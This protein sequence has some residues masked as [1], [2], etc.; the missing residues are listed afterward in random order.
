MTAEEGR[1]ACGVFGCIEGREEKYKYPIKMYG[2]VVVVDSYN[3][4]FCNTEDE[5]VFFRLRYVEKFAMR[6]KGKKMLKIPV[7]FKKYVNLLSENK[8]SMAHVLYGS[9]YSGLSRFPTLT[10]ILGQLI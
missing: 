9:E 7:K 5:L 10:I 6:I 8:R 2:T 4:L 3:L 1:A